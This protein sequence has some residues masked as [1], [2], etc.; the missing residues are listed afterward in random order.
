MAMNTL[1][2][3]KYNHFEQRRH[4]Y[5]RAIPLGI[6]K[7]GRI[8]GK[9]RCATANETFSELRNNLNPRISFVL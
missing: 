3:F 9:R 6:T 2:S 7:I 5:M 1:K 4:I 8:R